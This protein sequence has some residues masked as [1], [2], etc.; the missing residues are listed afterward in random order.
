VRNASVEFGS[1]NGFQLMM[2]TWTVWKENGARLAVGSNVL[3]GIEVLRHKNQIHN[4][5]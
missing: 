1:S 5:C 2:N 3:N 4:M